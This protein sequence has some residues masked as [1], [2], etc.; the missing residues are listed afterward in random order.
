MSSEESVFRR[1][2]HRRHFH[3]LVPIDTLCQ[4]TVFV[5]P[6]TRRKSVPYTGKYLK[7]QSPYRKSE[8]YRMKARESVFIASFGPLCQTKRIT[9]NAIRLTCTFHIIRQLL[10]GAYVRRRGNNAPWTFSRLS[11]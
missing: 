5:Q 3:H 1:A 11:C 2:H 6:L 8:K 9:V 10:I 7:R 4:R